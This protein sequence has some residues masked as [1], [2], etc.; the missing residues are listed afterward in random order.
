MIL[1]MIRQEKK[2]FLNKLF[3]VQICVLFMLLII[4]YRYLL[5]SQ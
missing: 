3:A 1:L 4:T 2:I 5:F